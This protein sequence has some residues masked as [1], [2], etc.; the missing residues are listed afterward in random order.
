MRSLMMLLVAMV[1]AGCVKR[2][3]DAPA[4]SF[5]EVPY[6]WPVKTVRLEGAQKRYGLSHA[7]KL[8]YVELNEGGAQTVLFLHGL[9]SSLKFWT[10]QLD[11]T[12][13]KGYRVIAIDQLGFG[14]SEKPATFP[15]TTESFAENVVELLDL[16]KLEQVI[17][18]GHSLGGQTALSTAIRFPQRVSSLVLVSPAGFETFS[19]R[20]QKW[21]KNV[22]SRSLVKDAD[23]E[24]IWGA[25]RY[26]NFQH[27]KPEYEW[28]VE[29]RVRLAKSPQFD[30]YAYAQVRAVEGLAKNDFVRESLGKVR[31]PT[32]IVY[33]TADRLI[34]NAFLH[35][36]LTKWTM[37][38]GHSQIAGS[39]LVALPGCGHTVQLDCSAEFNAALFAFLGKQPL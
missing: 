11:A 31:A 30:A 19:G 12:A 27:W 37:E 5:D 36:G 17:L 9:G 13:A 24:A 29:E 7:P 3:A 10:A 34:P 32:V 23:E 15:Y 8:S 20:E 25:I 14:K 39:E 35:G 1:S 22:Y 18:V 26:Q 28:L 4:L 6:A 21:F 33:G 2:Y 38:S 16:L